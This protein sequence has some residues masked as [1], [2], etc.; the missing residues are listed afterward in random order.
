MFRMCHCLI[1]DLID[2]ST[3]AINKHIG[4]ISEATFA[5]TASMHLCDTTD[6][7]LIFVALVIPGE[8]KNT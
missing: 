8:I 5:E 7:V 1:K 2:E 4:L 6:Y 3:Y